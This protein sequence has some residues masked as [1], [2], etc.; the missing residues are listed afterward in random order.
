ME[1]YYYT[2][3][4]GDQDDEVNSLSFDDFATSRSPF[5][6]FS[7]S[8]FLDPGSL[9]SED[10]EEEEAVGAW[11]GSDEGVP[12]ALSDAEDKVVVHVGYRHLGSGVSVLGLQVGADHPSTSRVA[13]SRPEVALVTMLARL[14]RQH[15]HRPVELRMDHTWLAKGLLQPD[16]KFRSPFLLSAVLALHEAASGHDVAVVGGVPEPTRLRV[17]LD[18]VQAEELRRVADVQ[19]QAASPTRPSV[20]FSSAL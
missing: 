1:L 6:S 11:D 4:I 16:R 7:G 19:G 18:A 3:S 15:R 9:G 20:V 10:W 17:M 2:D 14:A 12:P 13:H 8:P 5:P